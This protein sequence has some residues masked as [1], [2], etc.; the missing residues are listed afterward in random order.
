MS[1][2][3][4][5]SIVQRQ[6]RR[7]GFGARIVRRGGDPVAV[8]VFLKN[9]L[10]TVMEVEK[11]LKNTIPRRFFRQGPRGVVLFDVLKWAKTR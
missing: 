4:I 9:R 8:A 11:A 6:L 1:R 7:K 3:K 5:A 2:S 10:V